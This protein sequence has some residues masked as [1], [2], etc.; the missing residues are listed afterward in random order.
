MELSQAKVAILATDGFE[1][2]E[3]SRPA[4]ALRQAGVT[5][6]IIAPKDSTDDTIKAWA[7]DDWGDDYAIDRTL[8]DADTADYHA[9]VPPGGQINPDKLR[10]NEDAVQFVKDFVQSNKPVAAICHGPWLLAEADVLKGRKLTSFKSIKTDLQNAGAHWEDSAVVVD[11]H[12]ITSRNP[13]DLP[14]F[15]E[16][17]RSQLRAVN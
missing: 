12:L 14:G 1:E 3:L 7:E 8:K 15:I 5:V 2:S 9:L 6:H 17:I 16:A 4:E 10:I 11:E 13:N